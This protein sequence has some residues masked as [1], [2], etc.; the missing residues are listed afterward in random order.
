MAFRILHTTGTVTL[1][2]SPGHSLDL[3]FVF[4]MEPWPSLKILVVCKQLAT[5]PDEPKESLPLGQKGCV[6]PVSSGSP[7][8]RLYFPPFLEA[9]PELGPTLAASAS[10]G[11]RHKRSFEPPISLLSNSWTD[12][13]C[14]ACYC[15]QDLCQ[16]HWI[17]SYNS[18]CLAGA[19]SLDEK[20]QRRVC[21]TMRSI[22]W[23]P[24]SVL[25]ISNENSFQ[26][27]HMCV[28]VGTS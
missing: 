13:M 7:L 24:L 14:P 22:T 20:W 18:P 28:C 17:H 16:D 11:V 25:P 27:V 26:Y 15:S 2:E 4:C 10:V 6:E 1:V 21:D 23:L 5:L 3:L 8:Q 19:N 12:H 9:A